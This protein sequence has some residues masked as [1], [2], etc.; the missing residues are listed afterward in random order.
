MI[1]GA[2]CQCGKKV[3]PFRKFCPA[4][5]RAMEK[6]DFENIGSV[7]THTTLHAVPEGFEAPVRLAMI[8]LE[9]GA[10]LLCSVKEDTEVSIGDDVNVKR[11]GELYF[12]E[13]AH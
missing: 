2:T 5:G 9:G 10:N 13:H 7:L 4:C 11:E 3:V 1:P 12:C 6:A 8:E